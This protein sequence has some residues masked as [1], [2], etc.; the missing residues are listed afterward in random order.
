MRYFALPL[1]ALLIVFVA[2][3]DSNVPGYDD[4]VLPPLEETRKGV[5]DAGAAYEP[6]QVVLEQ[7]VN[8][9]TISDSLKR[10]IQAVDR[11]AVAAL[12]EYRA[13]VASGADDTTARLTAV[14]AILGRAQALLLEAQAE[15]V[16]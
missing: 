5:F 14:I 3:C 8:E 16:I 10:Q 13:A 9:P 6:V 15:G 11:E 2:A 12:Q 7:A 4:L 1:S